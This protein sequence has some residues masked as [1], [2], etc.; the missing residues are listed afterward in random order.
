MWKTTHSKLGTESNAGIEIKPN[1]LELKRIVKAAAAVLC[2]KNANKYM[3]GSII[4]K[5]Q[6]IRNKQLNIQQKPIYKILTPM[7][8]VESW[9]EHPQHQ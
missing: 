7:F 2:Q 3:Q 4:S 8:S 5:D 6:T 9:F 1:M